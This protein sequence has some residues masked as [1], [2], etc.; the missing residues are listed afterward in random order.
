MNC[1]YLILFIVFII[2]LF[3]LIYYN[4]KSKFSL[5]TKEGNTYI[6]SH[7]NHLDSIPMIIYQTEKNKN[8]IPDKVYKNIKT[9]ASNYK[10]FIYDDTECKAFLKKYYKP[11]V[12]D[13]F[14]SIQSG[15]HKADLWRYCIL[16]LYGGIYLDI[17]TVLIKPIKYIF[18]KKYTFY[19]I[20]SMHNNAIYQGIIA[21]PPYN[22]LFIELINEILHTPTN[23]LKH[24]YL[25]YTKQMYSILSKN[26]N[27][28]HGLNI[29]ISKT[30]KGNDLDFIM[31]NEKCGHGKEECK[32]EGTD[33]YGHCCNIFDKDIK[34]FKTRYKDYP[35]H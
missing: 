3:I 18:N 24:N 26:K 20:K 35:W 29:N 6:N 23:T 10:H 28:K 14:N 27:I 33:R 11:I 19:S 17:K 4:K 8:I 32:D 16:F 31:F 22:M 25:L 30:I 5:L 9:Y 13:K 7:L 2:I 12:L 15:A 21:T 1:N 34:Q